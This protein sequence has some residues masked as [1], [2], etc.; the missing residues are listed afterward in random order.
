MS[1]G[2]ESKQKAAANDDVAAPEMSEAVAEAEARAAEAAAEAEATEAA[3]E[4]EA[5]AE[6][7]DVEAAAPGPEEEIAALK[8][9]LL[10]AMAEIENTRR[11]SQRELNDTRKYAVAEFARDLLALA[12]NLE[13]AMASAKASDDEAGDQSAL[14]EGVELTERQFRQILEAHGI[15]R[16]EAEG[17]KLDPNLHQAMMQIDDAEAEPGTIVEVVQVGYTIHD[18]L[19]RPAMVAVA[20]APDA[21]PT[22]DAGQHLDTEA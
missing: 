19:L 20:K 16:I 2:N 10:R 11:R 22:P 15:R 4:A 1:E 18:R 3:A 9:Q 13:R 12:D 21:A 8:D 17:Q 14:V 6:T 5:A 7:E